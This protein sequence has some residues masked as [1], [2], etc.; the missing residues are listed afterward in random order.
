MKELKKITACYVDH[1]GLYLPLARKLSE[2][3]GRVLYY[4]P[5]EHAFPK[6][7][8]ALI[9]DGYPGL[10]RVDS[11]WDELS[12]IDLFVF[13]DSQGQQLQRHLSEMGKPVWGSRSAEDLEMSREEFHRVLGRVGLE[14]PKFERIIGTGRL[15]EYLRDKKDKFIKISKYRGS[16]ETCHWRSWEDDAV[17]IDSLAVK[18]GGIKEHI[19]F[20]VFDAIETDIELGGDTYSIDGAFPDAMMDGFEWKDK[21]YFGA[22]KPMSEMPE[23]T[24][25]VIQAFAPILRKSSHRNFWSMEIRVKGDH[26]Y[27]IDPTPRAPLPGTGSQMEIY[28]NLAEIIAAGANGDMVYPEP[29]GKFSAECVLTRKVD[30]IAWGS[31]R[32]PDELKQWMKISG[33][34]MVD[35][36]DWFPADDAHEAEIGW[37]VAIGNTPKETVET[38]LD[39]A[40]KL[41]DG[42]EA[43]TDSL[44]DLLKEIQ[45][46]EAEGIEFTPHKMPKPE[47]VITDS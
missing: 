37:L 19:P 25:E 32:V 6:V 46:A 3:Y 8:H 4:D 22:F 17:L 26:F 23:Q 41:P 12:S 27:F 35:G 1:G 14:V 42:I 20:L 38:M 18:F 7:N 5:C 11:F 9:G 16:L 10:E 39:H 24:M 36:R 30:P 34:C 13:P 44:I 45:K 47:S 43:N 29:A 2:S 33:S 15:A 40:S 28:S 31:V 21:G